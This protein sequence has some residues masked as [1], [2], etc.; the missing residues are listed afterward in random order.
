MYLVS[1]HTLYNTYDALGSPESQTK[2]Y[3]NHLPSF[4]C[5][6]L[7]LSKA[8]ICER[9]I[10]SDWSH[11]LIALRKNGLWQMQPSYINVQS[12]SSLSLYIHLSIHL[13]LSLSLYITIVSM[14]THRHRHTQNLSCYSVVMLH[15]GTQLFVMDDYVR[16]MTVKK[17]CKYGK[18][19]V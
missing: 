10:F 16:K 4:V 7:L 15:E 6:L 8:A 11:D 19:V 13:S 17:S 5:L 9:N 3:A 1:M 18:W 14:A 2:Y 12:Y